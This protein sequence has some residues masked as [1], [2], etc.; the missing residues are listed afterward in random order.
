M[1]SS[2][3]TGKYAPLAPHLE[4]GNQNQNRFAPPPPPEPAPAT[5]THTHTS[6]TRSR[7]VNKQ[8]KSKKSFTLNKKKK[9]HPKKTGSFSPVTTITSKSASKTGMRLK[10]VKKKVKRQHS[11]HTSSAPHAPTQHTRSQ[12]QKSVYQPPVVEEKP[13]YQPPEEVSPQPQESIE[14]IHKH[15]TFAP[16]EE[17][18]ESPQSAVQPE[19]Q[20]VQ[21][22]EVNTT[23]VAPQVD[24]AVKAEAE[25]N[26]PPKKEV[27]PEKKTRPASPA[28]AMKAVSDIQSKKASASKEQNKSER[29]SKDK[30]NG[31]GKKNGEKKKKAGLSPLPNKKKKASDQD[32]KK[33]NGK[34]SD[35]TATGQKPLGKKKNSNAGGAKK[36]PGRKKGTTDNNADN[37]EQEKEPAIVDG[38]RVT[39]STLLR[40]QTEKTKKI[41]FIIGVIIGTIGLIVFILGSCLFSGSSGH[42]RKR[43]V[44]VNANSG[45]GN[46]YANRS[47]A[48]SPISAGGSGSS[49]QR[50]KASGLYQ[51][52]KKL[53][54]ETKGMSQKSADDIQVI[55]E[56]WEDFVN[57][58]QENSD[59]PKYQDALDQIENLKK[60]K[61]MYEGF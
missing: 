56:L 3:I 29:K 17:I 49:F 40:L 38:Y 57:D 41:K 31:N 7:P 12:E 44:R 34:K 59:D 15:E 42:K 19:P 14:N 37:L 22:P 21:E 2:S 48:T 39:H 51:K 55:I 27:K 5:H 61:E 47:K 52:F 4:S 8:S 18:Y 60:T 23:E 33:S 43:K 58:N 46:Y 9:Q 45:V 30:K 25:M 32:K 36:N 1:L 24:E 13:I 54:K 11:H 10:P 6:N 50:P 20:Q 26:E 35:K 16:Q 53:D 28:V